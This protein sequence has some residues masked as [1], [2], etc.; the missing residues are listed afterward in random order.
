MKEKQ[1]QPKILH[2][3]KIS[4]KNK[5]KIKF[6]QYKQLKEFISSRSVVQEKL[7]EG[8]QAKKMKADKNLDYETE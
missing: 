6:Q 4:L 8:L 5:D 7:K 1:C 3:S 2:S